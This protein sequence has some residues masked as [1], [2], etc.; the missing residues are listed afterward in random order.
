M[1]FDLEQ[2]LLCTHFSDPDQVENILSNIIS[3]T[4]AQ[5]KEVTTPKEENGKLLDRFAKLEKRFLTQ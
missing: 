4:K 1:S 3:I 5:N 2:H